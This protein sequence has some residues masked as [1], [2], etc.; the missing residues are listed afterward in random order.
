MKSK[1]LLFEDGRH[2]VVTRTIV[3]DII[4]V[5]KNEEEGEF[6]LPNY[7]DDNR[8]I[9]DFPGIGIDLAV[10]LVVEINDTIET[11]KVDANY[12]RDDEIIQIIIEYNPKNKR[13]SLYDLVG[14]LNEVIAHEFRHTQQKRKGTFNLDVP[15]ETDP[16]KYYT[17]EHELDAQR[18]GFKRLAKITKTPF[19]V[20]VKRWF[21]THKDVHNLNDEQVKEVI[22]KILNN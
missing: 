10:E 4:N 18:F 13:T 16:F 5:F 3:R 1:F 8:E 9:Y 2:G 17:Q 20:I 12:F 14:E 7:I 11:F 21:Q 22:S 19:D 6:Y 15:E